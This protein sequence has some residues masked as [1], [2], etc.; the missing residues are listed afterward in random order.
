[1]VQ[2][3]YLH[4]PVYTAVVGAGV[5]STVGVYVGL[6]PAFCRDTFPDAKAASFEGVGFLLSKKI[7][8]IMN[9]KCV[10]S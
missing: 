9:E 7:S 3:G 1:M 10:N 4:G 5:L 2:T 8:F 6:A